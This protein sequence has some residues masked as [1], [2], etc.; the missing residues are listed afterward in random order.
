[1]EQLR[2]ALGERPQ[3]R[4][5]RAV[6]ARHRDRH[7]RVAEVGGEAGFHGAGHKP[8]AIS[9]SSSLRPRRKPSRAACPTLA[10]FVAPPLAMTKPWIFSGF[11]PPSTPPPPPQT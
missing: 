4:E 6:L 3:R 9:S 2:Q 8:R 1:M 10:C 7:A 5:R 11:T